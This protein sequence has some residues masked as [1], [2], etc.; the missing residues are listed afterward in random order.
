LKRRRKDHSKNKKRVIKGGKKRGRAKTSKEAQ[1]VTAFME[2]VNSKKE[3]GDLDKTK[4]KKILKDD[5][6]DH[7]KASTRGYWTYK[8]CW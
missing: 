3:L 4:R 1:E 2:D 6:R 7:C 5:P 8:E